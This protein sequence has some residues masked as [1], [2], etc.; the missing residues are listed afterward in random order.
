MGS[1]DNREFDGF[2][3]EL[4]YSMRNNLKAIHPASIR[5]QRVA[6]AASHHHRPA[7]DALYE[8]SYLFAYRIEIPENATS[9]TL[10]NARFVR[11]VALSVGDEGNAFVLQSP[12]EDLYRDDDFSKRFETLD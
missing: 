7:G 12:F 4:S 8:Y 1:W 6:W 11:I 10:P 5:N 2:V 9:I 3:A